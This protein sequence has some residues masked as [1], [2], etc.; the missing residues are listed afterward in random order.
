ME[1]G[2]GPSQAQMPLCG[3]DRGWRLEVYILNKLLGVLSINGLIIP[4]V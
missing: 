3:P 4:Y 1:L 2:L